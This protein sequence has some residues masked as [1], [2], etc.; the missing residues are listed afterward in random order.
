MDVNRLFCSPFYL[1]IELTPES[2]IIHIA[3][4]VRVL[5]EL[6][7]FIYLLSSMAFNM[8]VYLIW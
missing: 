1:L 5:I 7:V 3:S 2:Y 6:N 4:D 8:I